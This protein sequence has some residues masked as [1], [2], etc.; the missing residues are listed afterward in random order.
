MGDHDP[1]GGSKGAAELAIRTYQHSFFP[2]QDLQRHGIKLAS[3]RA[4]NV[5]GG[6]DWT[7]HAL[8][9][10]VAKA[11]SANQPVALRSPSAFRPWQHVLQAL[12]G[13]LTLA[14]RLLESDDPAYCGGWNFGPVPGNEISVRQVVDIFL[15]EWG[16]G[17]WIDAS[18]SSNPREANILRLSI[19]KALWELDWSP[20]W[21]VSQVLNQTAR[22]Y[23]HHNDHG[24]CMREFSM[25]QVQDYQQ[26]FFLKC[27]ER[28]GN[29]PDVES[30][31][32]APA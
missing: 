16:S 32:L 23:R 5:I 21:S 24:G 19:D 15:K 17:S 4:G 29:T 2:P 7:K 25:Q 22:W 27:A 6:G 9:V 1:Y 12:S 14:A 10:D 26:E 11:L 31:A 30:P 8:I 28:A 20:C 18:D 13:Y 3:A